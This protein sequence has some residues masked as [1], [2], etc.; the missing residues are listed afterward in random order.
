MMTQNLTPSS[1][2][3]IK[4][5]G[6]GQAHNIAINTKTGYAYTAGAEL[7]GNRVDP[8]LVFMLLNIS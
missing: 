3:T 2:Y 1:L 8:V 6:Y 7:V 5:S 4:Y